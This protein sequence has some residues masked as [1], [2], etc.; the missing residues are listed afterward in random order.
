MAG[1]LNNKERVMDFTVTDEGK[2]QASQGEMR[3]KFATFTDLHTFYDVSGSEEFPD[4]SSDGSERIFFETY[5]RYQDVVVPELEAGMSLRPFRTKDFEV[6]GGSIAS[7]S[8]FTGISSHPNLL[9]GSAVTGNIQRVLDGITQ[10]FSD[11]RIIGSI[12]EF[13]LFEDIV[14]APLTG[15]YKLTSQTEFFRASQETGKVMLEDIPSIFQDRRFSHFPNFMY[16]PPENLPI[17]GAS[18]GVPLGNYPSFAEKSIITQDQI[19]ESLLKSDFTDVSFVETSR[20][21]NIA[22]QFFEAGQGNIEKL[23]IIDFGEFEDEDPM[24][25]GRRVVY[26]GKLLRDGFGSETFSCIFT[27]V[28]D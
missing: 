9:T 2:R 11:Q 12:D 26:V 15:T 16:L 24:S 23:S 4:L 8:A 19:N 28:I 22:I 21:N 17:P 18:S 3:F 7:G 13:S 1:I 14:L 25:P 20:K 10:N 5:S 27:A 6:S